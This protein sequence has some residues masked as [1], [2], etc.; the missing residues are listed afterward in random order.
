MRRGVDVDM[1]DCRLP[2]RR[3]NSLDAN[4]VARKGGNF[5][6]NHGAQHLIMVISFWGYVAFLPAFA[7]AFVVFGLTRGKD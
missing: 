2:R 4:A 6:M 1:R 5:D 7:V 3:N